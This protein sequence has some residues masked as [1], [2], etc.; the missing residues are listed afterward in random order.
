MIGRVVSVNVPKR[1][2]RIAPETSYPERF[3][4]LEELRLKAKDGSESRLALD[5]IRITNT[6]IIVTAR[7]D[8]ADEVAALLFNLGVAWR[9]VDPSLTAGDILRRAAAP[10][11]SS[12]IPGAAAAAVPAGQIGRH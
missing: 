1:Q 11:R 3:R 9:E 4:M 10:L 7:T 8:S 5:D 2:L 12:T 6:V